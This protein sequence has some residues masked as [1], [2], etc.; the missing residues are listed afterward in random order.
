MLLSNILHQ[1]VIKPNMRAMNKTQAMDEL[2]DLLIEAGEVP[3]SLRNHAI[4]TINDREKLVGTGME[5]GVALPH[6]SSDRIQSI[7]CAL[8][9]SREGVDWESRDGE[10]ARIIVLLLIPRRSYQEH[11]RAM[12]ATARVM[13][14]KDV[15][16]ALLQ[17]DA[18]DA[19]LAIIEEAELASEH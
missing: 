14:Q 18:V 5:N 17:A 2:V 1:R 10:L 12:T 3:L 16:Q 4:Q 6:G 8:G 15:R 19:I 11:L 13:R 9:I 7:V